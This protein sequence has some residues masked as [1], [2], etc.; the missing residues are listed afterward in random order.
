MDLAETQI[1]LNKFAKY[2]V[3]QARA[4]LTRGQ[5]NVSKDL[6]DS[7]EFNPTVRKNSLSIDFIMNEYGVFQDR[8]VKGTKSG[9][10]LSGF[11]Y[12]SSSNLV[13]MEYHTGT[14]RKWAKFR[15]IQ[16]RDKRGR[17]VSYES[18]GYALANIIKK[19][20]IKPS[21]FFTK[22]FEKAF[23][24]LPS[25]L[26]DAFALDIGNTIELTFKDILK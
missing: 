15:G 11:K 23:K 20:G 3:S 13:G 16:F 5:K 24:D 2:V 26:L 8:G 4:N 25:D 1:V 10:S 6:W 19:K 17:F 22:P 12:K 7:I 14:F 18:T 9:K 21:L